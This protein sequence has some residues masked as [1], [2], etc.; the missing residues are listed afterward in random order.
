MKKLFTILGLT[1]MCNTGFSQSDT[2]YVV[3]RDTVYVDLLPC[4]KLD[5]NQNGFVDYSDLMNLLGFWGGPIICCPEG[6]ENY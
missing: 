6:E 5:Y 3:V 2:V 1:F 4:E